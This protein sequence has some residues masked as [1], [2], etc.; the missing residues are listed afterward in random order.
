M[1]VDQSETAPL[2]IRLRGRVQGPFSTAQLQALH[3]RGQF[4]R[5]HEV[6]E[7]RVNWRPAATL[8]HVF[9]A[10]KVRPLPPQKVA[11]RPDSG[12]EIIALGTEAPEKS[13]AAVVTGPARLA[14]PV[15]HYSVGK[16]TYGPVTI[17]ELRGLLAGG[18]L[19]GSDLI[20]KD[21]L[22]DWTP[23]SE[24]AEL[25]GAAGPHTPQ[26]SAAIRGRTVYCAACGKSMDFRAE[27]CPQCGVRA[28][29]PVT[30][31]SRMVTAMLAIFLGSFGLHRFYLG[32]AIQ[33]LSYTFTWAFFMIAAFVFMAARIPVLAGICIFMSV[34]PTLFSFI[35]GVAF[36]CTSDADFA[37]RYNQRR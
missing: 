15:W 34:L 23:A 10:P 8:S 24:V 7:D 33:G 13:P 21:G 31:K 16:E 11:P 3:E 9:V 5:A 26:D 19:Q 30:P 28:L 6:S 37:Q 22:P 14:K 35:E 17:L 2:F 27:I 1:S 36:L 4:S 29:A 12:D 25:S 32:Q 20:W 18:Q